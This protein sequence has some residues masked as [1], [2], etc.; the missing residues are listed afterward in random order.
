MEQRGVSDAVEFSSNPS[1]THATGRETPSCGCKC[2]SPEIMQSK[3]ERAMHSPSPNTEQFTLR[4]LNSG[5]AAVLSVTSSSPFS[6]PTNSSADRVNSPAKPVLKKGEAIDLVDVE[7]KKKMER[8]ISHATANESLVSAAR[9]VVQHDFHHIQVVQSNQDLSSPSQGCVVETPLYTFTLPD[10]TSYPEDFRGFL[11]KDL[12][13]LSALIS[14]EQTGRL[15]WWADTGTCQRL[16]PLATTGDGNCLLHAASLGMWGFHDRLLTLRKA[17]YTFLTSGQT[18]DAIYRRWRWSAAQQN[19]QSGLSLTESEWSEEWSSVLR[20]ASTEPR[21]N[22][23]MPKRRS[24]LSTVS[25]DDLDNPLYESLEEI[26]VLVLAHILRRPII[27]VADTVLKDAYGEALAPIPFGGIY[28]PLEVSPSECDKCPLIL[29]YDAGHFSALVTMQPPANTQSPLPTVIPVTDSNHTIL[30]IQ[31]SVDPGFQ[32]DWGHDENNPN[33][34]NKLDLHDSDKL[35]LLKEFLDVVQVP[36]PACFLDPYPDLDLTSPDSIESCSLKD[37]DV[38][39]QSSQDLQPPKSKTA[40]QIQSVAKQFGSIGK[41]V[42][43]KIKKNFGNITRLARTGSFK[44]LRSRPVSQTTRLQTCRIVGGQQDHI[45]AAMLHTQKSLPYLQEMIDNYLQEAKFR[46]DKDKEL[47]ALQAAER[48]KKECGDSLVPRA[49]CVSP[50]CQLMGNVKTSYLCHHCFH[51]QIQQSSEA[52]PGVTGYGP[53]QQSEALYGSGRSKFY[54][55]AD[56]HSYETLRNVPLCKHPSMRNSDRSLYLSNSTFYRDGVAGLIVPIPANS[57]DPMPIVPVDLPPKAPL[58]NS[59]KKALVNLQTE[60][61]RNV[62]NSGD[63]LDASR[64]F[65]GETHQSDFERPAN[66]KYGGD[67]SKSCMKVELP[68]MMDAKPCQTSGC[69]FFGSS[70]NNSFCSKCFRE[71]QRILQASKV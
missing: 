47:K 58:R 71:S 30:P 15:N 17:L 40:K 65:L 29:T 37:V 19:Y 32:I 50:E 20:L 69:S 43:K 25:E 2:Q 31:F 63:S 68:G 9:T 36:L 27:V 48:R 45:L 53:G 5:S 59:R 55:N 11:E 21:T 34:L 42:S 12:I 22:S 14:L 35:G 23:N 8:G 7:A 54:V 3:Q 28:L 67:S 4:K 64:P 70:E 10:L 16:W 38:A 39:S 41:T 60:M 61:S 6:S 46:F 51:Q 1:E 56:D 52:R 57:P 26:H 44:G 66:L 24:R 18:V 13:E 62:M 49:Q 33:I